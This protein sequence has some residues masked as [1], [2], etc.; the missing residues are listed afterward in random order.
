MRVHGHQE[1]S[2]HDYARSSAVCIMFGWLEFYWLG[3]DHG[4]TLN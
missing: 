4:V 3:T 2:K 1:R